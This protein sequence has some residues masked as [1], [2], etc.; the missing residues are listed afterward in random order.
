[1][2]LVLLDKGNIFS[3]SAQVIVNPVN[4]QGVM[5]AGLAKKFKEYYPEMFKEYKQRCDSGRLILGQIHCWFDM[6]EDKTMSRYICNLPTKDDWRLP[7]E[8]LFVEMGLVSLRKWML[9]EGLTGVA[10]PALGCG[11]GGLDFDKVLEIIHHVFDDYDIT[12]IV[13]KPQ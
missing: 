11:L 10:M 9:S 7:S 1:M 8:Y 3:A 6:S 5:G 2:K 4:T 13:Y 12:V